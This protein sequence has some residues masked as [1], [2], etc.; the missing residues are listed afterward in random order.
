MLKHLKIEIDD[1]PILLECASEVMYFGVDLLS[2][3]GKKFTFNNYVDKISQMFDKVEKFYKE[4]KD[5]DGKLKTLESQRDYVMFVIGI[6]KGD[7][8]MIGVLANKLGCF[9]N[10]IVKALF[11]I[12]LRYKSVI[13]EDGAFGLPSI[14]K[15]LRTTY[16]SIEDDL[17]KR[18]YRQLSKRGLKLAS[19]ALKEGAT[20]IGIK[21]IDYSNML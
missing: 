21:L 20:A 12:L 5:V 7:F 17:R 14:A 18:N 6:C 19:Q 9:D 8:E 4:I 11:Q 2:E 16:F 13:F 10:D 15:G 1:Y 3:E